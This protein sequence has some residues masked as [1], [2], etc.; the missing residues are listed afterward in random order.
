MDWIEVSASTAD[1]AKDEALSRLG[2]GESDAEIIV[3]EA[4]G[5]VFR[6]LIK[7]N[8][9]IRARIRPVQ[10][11]S[12][13]TGGGKAR[14]SAAEK[15]SR[16]PSD[17]QKR[18]RSPGN[19]RSAPAS[20]NITNDSASKNISNKHNNDQRKSDK[21]RAQSNIAKDQTMDNGN[22]SDSN[23][24]IDEERIRNQA[25]RVSE[26][27]LGLCNSFGISPSVSTE[28]SVT[29]DGCEINATGDQLGFLIGHG[30]TVLNALQ[31]IA[32]ASLYAQEGEIVGTVVVD[33]ASYRRKRAIA[34]EGFSTKQAQRVRDT[35][36]EIAIEHMSSPERKIIHEAI[37]ELDGVSTRSEG[38]E[39]RRVV[40]IFATDTSG[41]DHSTNT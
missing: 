7:H 32:K 12:A 5:G 6:R 41:E 29:D 39:P 19:K 37:K 21:V 1:R 13:R 15:N 23:T 36:R 9:R 3:L 26:F 11:R 17:R 18:P 31:E 38:L 27:V 14:K 28:I 35:G 2:V 30:G 4:Q 33:V 10:A 20:R 34:L 24:A 25:N 40:I 8:V 22:S 16:D